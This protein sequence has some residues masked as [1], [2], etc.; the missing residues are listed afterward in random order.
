VPR[1]KLSEIALPMTRADIGSYLGL[2][3]ETVVRALAKLRASRGDYH[4]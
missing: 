1:E 2:A 4:L 3:E